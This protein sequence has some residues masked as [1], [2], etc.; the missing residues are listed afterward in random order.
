LAKLI[1]ND[2]ILEFN[3]LGCYDYQP[4]EFEFK[5]SLF[6]KGIPLLNEKAM[7][8]WSTYW[9]KGKEGGLVAEEMD[10]FTL[11]DD[12]EKAIETNT[13]QVWESWPDPDMCISIYPNR[14]FPY[15]DEED[16]EY[17]T[18]I[19]SP[20]MYQFKESDA[21]GGYEGVSFIMT[22]DKDAFLKFVNELKDEYKKIIAGKN[23]KLN[24]MS[25]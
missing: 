9:R 7:K 21:Y 5:V 10:N 8:R 17:N 18:I 1:S 3:F 16:P 24:T 6:W 20:D 2:L 15:L 4:V 14:C 13:L 12:L 11:I 25:S 22:P 23:L 19:V